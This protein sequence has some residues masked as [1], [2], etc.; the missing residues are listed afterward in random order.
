M[1]A[2]LR[3]DWNRA[4]IQHIARLRVAPEE[5]DRWTVIGETDQGRVLIIVYTMRAD[6]VRVVTSYQAGR[7]MREGY[8]N[9]K[10]G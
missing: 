8:L 7:R 10:G 3:F 1:A 2:A 5:V 6:Q 9:A 4:N